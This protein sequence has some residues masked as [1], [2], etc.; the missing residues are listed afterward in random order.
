MS[1][2]YL[3]RESRISS[4]FSCYKLEIVEGVNEQFVYQ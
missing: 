3:N 2:A 1:N 4:Y